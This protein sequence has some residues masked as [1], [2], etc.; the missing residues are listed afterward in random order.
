MCLIHSCFKIT[1]SVDLKVILFNYPS[2]TFLKDSI[3][4]LQ[5]Y[6]CNLHGLFKKV[7]VLVGV[8]LAHLLLFLFIG[9]TFLAIIKQILLN[10][11]EIQ[12]GTA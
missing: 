8:V 2:Y 6:P 5:S 11:N 7:V 12:S 3:M 9:N 4:Y 1:N 10:G